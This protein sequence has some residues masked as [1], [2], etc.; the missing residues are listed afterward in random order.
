MMALLSPDCSPGTSL[1]AAAW[2]STPPC[3]GR[4]PG[5]LQRPASHTGGRVPEAYVAIMELKCGQGNR[6]SLFCGFPLQALCIGGLPYVL[7]AVRNSAHQP[8]AER[9]GRV[10]P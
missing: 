1:S 6:E 9:D 3:C 10:P 7:K 2:P 5:T 8:H 4:L